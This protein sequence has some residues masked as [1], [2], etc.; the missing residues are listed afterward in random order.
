MAVALVSSALLCAPVAALAWRIDG[1]AWPYLAA[2]AALELAYF[3]LLAAAYRRAELSLV[4]PVA[5]GLAPVVVLACAVVFTGAATS[6][7]QAA[8]VALV[9]V[10]VLLVRGLRGGDR[11]GLAFGIAI[12][13]CIGAYTVVDKEG[14]E[15]AAPLAY[16]EVVTATMGVAYAV[17]L[18]AVR[19]PAALRAEVSV[20][21]VVAGIASFAAYGMVLAALQL[22]PAASVAAVRETSVLIAT[23]LAAVVLRERVT[24]ARLAGAAFVVAGVALLTL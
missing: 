14:V 9:G 10:G 22:A 11:A 16:L 12:A 21:A 5:R 8:G 20:R 24:R 23:A 4:Y 15:H 3:S 13:C 19:G 2:S 1:G 17:V 7:A 18:G 6:G